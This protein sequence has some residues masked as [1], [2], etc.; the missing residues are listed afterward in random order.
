VLYGSRIVAGAGML[1]PT[2][3]LAGCRGVT[4]VPFRHC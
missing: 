4:E 2:I 3:S 1:I